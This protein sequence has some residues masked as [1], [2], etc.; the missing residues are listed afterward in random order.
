VD[1]NDT[2]FA[3]GLAG[4]SHPQECNEADDDY[5]PQHEAILLERKEKYKFVQNDSFSN[6]FS[7]FN[8]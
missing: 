5:D 6:L 3:S 4:S 2:G 7:M 1:G 8:P